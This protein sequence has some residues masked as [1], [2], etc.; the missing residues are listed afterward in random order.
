[1]TEEKSTEDWNFTTLE[2]VVA[3]L[4]LVEKLFKKLDERITALEQRH[5]KED[6]ELE[7]TVGK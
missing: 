2:R 6:A 1:M 4:E 7:R 3:S 5:A